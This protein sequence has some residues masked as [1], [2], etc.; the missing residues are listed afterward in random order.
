[1]RM[2]LLWCLMVIQLLL[3]RSSACILIVIPFS[4][5]YDH[6][7]ITTLEELVLLLLHCTLFHWHS[8]GALSGNLIATHTLQ[9][10]YYYSY[11]WREGK[12]DWYARWSFVE[13]GLLEQFVVVVV[14]VCC[15]ELPEE[16]NFHALFPELSHIHGSHIT[17]I[18]PLEITGGYFAH[19]THALWRYWCINWM[20]FTEMQNHF[21]QLNRRKL[22][23]PPSHKDARTIQD[24][25]RHFTGN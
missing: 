21:T 7:L 23:Y 4:C 10:P 9:L 12:A 11:Y 16:C 8:H 3:L 25:H 13:V 5:T 2:K 1:M 17:L 14:V 20:T 19:Y 15:D 6:E 24:T 22:N 18:K